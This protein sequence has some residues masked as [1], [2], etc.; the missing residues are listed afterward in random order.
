MTGAAKRA[1][2]AAITSPLFTTILLLFGSGVPT[3]E[4][5]TAER[6]YLLSHAPSNKD[7]YPS[8]WEAYKEYLRSTSILIPLPPAV[9]RSLPAV[10]KRWLLLDLPFYAF[11]EKTDGPAALEKERK[12][13]D[14]DRQ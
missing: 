10:V 14:G 7:K 13:Q 1:Q 2:Y 9:Y 3:A 6:F 12:K 11:D 5:P 4:K 8:A